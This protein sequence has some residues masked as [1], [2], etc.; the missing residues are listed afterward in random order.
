VFGAQ[1]SAAGS[2]ALDGKPFLPAGPAEAIARGIAYLPPDRALDASFHAMSV[3]ANLSA[4]DVR[5]YFRGLRLRH[6]LEHDDALAAID[7]FA[8]RAASDLQPL[9]TL[10]GGNQQKVVLSRWLRDSPRL[11]LLDEPTQGVAAHARQEIHALL[12]QAARDGT[13]LLVVSSDFEELAQLCDRVLVVAHGSIAGEIRPPE[14]DS[15]RLTEL[16]HFA[17]VPA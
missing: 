9:A 17:Q 5:R 16:A 1:P 13:G 8:I 2:L 12:R 14:L 10:S 7:R 6:D 4:V 11:F 3:R 15:H